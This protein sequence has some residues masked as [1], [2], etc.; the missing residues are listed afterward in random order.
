MS[1]RAAPHNP[2][3]DPFGEPM[4]LPGVCTDPK[5]YGETRRVA[6]I[7]W[8]LALIFLGGRIYLSAPPVDEAASPVAVQVA[9]LR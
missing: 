7:F 1:N 5:G 6:L 3:F 8:A 9:D 4:D 2:V